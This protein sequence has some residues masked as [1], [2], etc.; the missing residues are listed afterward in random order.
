[1]EQLLEQLFINDTIDESR[2]PILKKK[3]RDKKTHREITFFLNSH[4]NFEKKIW[5]SGLFKINDE[6]W[7]E[8]KTSD[9]KFPILAMVP[10]FKTV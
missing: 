1:M 6:D 10:R 9:I 5:K 4:F 7:A 8:S 2:F 3:R